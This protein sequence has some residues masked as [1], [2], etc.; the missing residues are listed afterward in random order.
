MAV[1]RNELPFSADL[2]TFTVDQQRKDYHQGEQDAAERLAIAFE[3]YDYGLPSAHI[4]ALAKKWK[5]GDYSKLTKEDL[6]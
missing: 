6:K 3:N 2:E 4:R 5:S 1:D